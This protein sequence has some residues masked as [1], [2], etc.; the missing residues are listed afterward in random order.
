M[1]KSAKKRK[2]KAADFT[3]AKLKLGKEKKA[4]SNVIDTSFKARSIALP[5][6]SIG[7]AKDENTPTTRRK[8]S[9]ND[10]IAHLKHYSP[11]VKKD[12]LAGL[13]EL[14]EAHWTLVDH[15]LT[16]LINHV[17]R[18][19]G[20]EDAGVRKQLLSFLS[21]LL[22]RLSKED[23]IPH[24][25]TLL[26]F[27]TS[28]QTH[29][30]PEIRIDAVRFLTLFLEQIP[31]SL[32]DGWNVTGP[33]HGRRILE[34]YLGNLNAGTKFGGAEGPPAATSS[35]SVILS[36]ISKLAVLQS[37]SSFLRAGLTRDRH[38][39]IS[40]S[41]DVPLHTWFMSQS[42]TSRGAYQKFENTLMPASQLFQKTRFRTQRTPTWIYARNDAH[43]YPQN[44][45]FVDYRTSWSVQ[46]IED[47]VMDSGNLSDGPSV[48]DSASVFLPHLARTLH[49]ILVS[50]I[51][52]CAPSVFAPDGKGS[53]TEASM[54]MAVSQV[55]SL[56]YG[57][58]IGGNEAAPASSLSELEVLLG[59]M[60]PYFPFASSKSRDVKF[61]QDFQDMNLIHCELTSL[62]VLRSN[63]KIM[64]IRLSNPNNALILQIATVS[65]FITK[66][67]RGQSTSNS[68]IPR[69]IPAESY[70]A[71]LPSIWAIINNPYT[72]LRLHTTDILHAL[73]NHANK[74]SS[75]S[76]A[77]RPSIEF[78]ARL[79]LLETESQYQGAFKIWSNYQMQQQFEDW[80]VHLPQVLWEIGNNDL[81]ATEVILRFLLRLLQR[82]S[83]FVQPKAISSL[84]FRLVPYFTVNHPVR[85]QLSGPYSKLPLTQSHV[86][87]LCLDV[88]S[89][90]LVRGGQ[91]GAG[92]SEACDALLKAVDLVVTDTI[93]GEYWVHVYKAVS[94]S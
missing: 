43:E 61:T 52:D 7:A 60:T 81:I 64:Q 4:P 66:L 55:A 32:V 31:E 18:M 68:Q 80:L 59:Y 90:L 14:L 21:W 2:D 1:P 86:R 73:L 58:I 47:V 13:S 27:T 63:P 51:L 16:Q 24:A 28:A 34:G 45:A 44:Y 6:Q 77:K 87:R 76:S 38:N 30:F 84:G 36:P 89:T 12:A 72:E 3:K 9:I 11:S 48:E 91:L 65:D 93:E 37:F 23:L 75:K 41:S 82:Q 57:A 53:D 42:F 39:G 29:I 71:L 15:H 94:S 69:S 33:S 74:T 92:V 35:A 25:S 88:V 26:L 22:P 20:D 5:T 78:V 46:E 62:L 79:M 85:G 49:P 10:L 67:L 17:A 54:M 40:Q 19:I 50:T 83:P 70:L 56:L 8:L